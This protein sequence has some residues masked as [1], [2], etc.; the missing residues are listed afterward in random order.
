MDYDFETVVRRGPANLKRIL[1]DPAVLSHG[2]VSFDGAEPDYP[3]APVIADAVRRL[4]ENGLY[5]FTVADDTYRA[6]VVWWFEH[7]RGVK[8]EPEWIVPALGTIHALAST[9]RLLCPGKNDAVMVM[10]PVYNRF[11][12]AA[13]RL[14]RPVVPCPLIRG[15]GRYSIDFAKMDALLSEKRVR[16]LVVCNPQNPIGQIW[17]EEELSA[18]ARTAAR[19]DV[20]IFCDEIFAD[21]VYSGRICPSMLSVPEAAE[22]ALVASSLGKA[23]GLTGLNHANILV[24]SPAL[25][26]AFA[27]RR[28][29]DHYGSMDPLAYECLLAAYSP[30]GLDWVRSSNRLCEENMRLVRQTFARLFPKAGVYGG[31]GAYVL[32]I[33][34][35]K[36]F[37]SE[38]KMLDFLYHRAFFHVDAGSAYGAPG[39]I[40]MCAASP[41][42]C[43]ERA[44]RDLEAAWK[45]QIKCC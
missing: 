25:R 38:Q 24:R 39:F 44:M 40:R 3:T 21:S 6:R 8:A 4:A 26:E 1:T 5:G 36:Y 13:A 32:W 17:T 10:P 34:L 20:Y 43:V 16:L 33:D 29:R 35:T 15:E 27:D 41:A 18:L 37:D 22:R 11:A 42:R 31:E 2:N 7:S 23:F 30:E 45:E 19:H 28:T 12:Q 14:E 9:I